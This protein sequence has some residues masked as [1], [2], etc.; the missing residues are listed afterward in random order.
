MSDNPNRDPAGGQQGGTATETPPPKKNNAV[1]EALKKAAGAVRRLAARAAKA[2]RPV[3]KKAANA[4][5]AVFGKQYQAL[6]AT[7]AKHPQQ[8]LAGALALVIL[9]VFCFSVTR[10]TGEREI[11]EQEEAAVEVVA[12]EDF[13]QSGS[14]TLSGVKG[15]SAEDVEKGLTLN[16]RA[17]VE[18]VKD[19]ADDEAVVHIMEPRNIEYTGTFRTGKAGDADYRYHKF[20]LNSP[21]LTVR[22]G[23]GSSRIESYESVELVFSEQVD[24]YSLEQNLSIIPYSDFTL[25]YT[26]NTVTIIPDYGWEA[27]GG[28]QIQ[29][30]ADYA[31]RDGK[32]FIQNQ[33]LNFTVKSAYTPSGDTYVEES[34]SSP[35]IRFESNQSLIMNGEN[36][37]AMIFTADN[38]DLKVPVLVDT[39]RMND[40][41][42]YRNQGSIYLNYDVKLDALEKLDTNAFLVDNGENRFEVPHD[43][44][45][46]YILA[47]TYKD[48]HTGE[49][50]Q[51]RTSYLVTPISVYM[52]ATAMET[53]VWLNSAGSESPLAG[54]TVVFE[55][56]EQPEEPLTTD[57]QGILTVAHT[58]AADYDYY[59][60]KSSFSVYD[61][62]GAL[63]YYDNS[64]LYRSFNY[65]DRYYSTLFTDRT[66]YKPEDTVHFWGFV[67]PY[68]YNRREMPET[69]TV[70]FDEGG[71]DI[72][73]EVEISENGVFHG[74]VALEQ[75]K[76]SQYAIAAALHF[77]GETEEDAGTRHVLRTE[78][79]SVKEF[80][81]PTFVLDSTT[82]KTIYG[83]DDEVTVTV[84]ASFYDGSPLPFYPLEVSYHD[85]TTY[86]K[87]AIKGV[88]TDSSGTATFTFPANP[89]G[90][91]IGA[92]KSAYSGQYIVQIAS[93]G[94]QVTHVN[95][96]RYL[97]SDTLL[98]YSIE[99]QASGDN[100]QMTVRAYAVDNAA[101][102]AWLENGGSAYSLNN[103]T[104]LQIARG[105]PRDLKL[106]VDLRWGYTDTLSIRHHNAFR[107]GSGYIDYKD[108]LGIRLDEA[109][110]SVMKIIRDWE[111][112]VKQITVNTTDG[113]AVIPDLI[114]KPE[115][116]LID[117]DEPLRMRA[118]LGY[119]DGKENSCELRATY[120][121]PQ[122]PGY[123]WDGEFESE[124]QS[125]PEKVIIPGYSFAVTDTGDGEDLT[126]G[127]EWLS[128][129]TMDA[130]KP[131]RFDLLLDSEPVESGGRVLYTVIQNGVY[132]YGVAGSS[133]QLPYR[134][135]YGKSVRLIAAYFDGVQT[136]Y[137]KQLDLYSSDESLKIDLD[138]TPDR[139]SYR[140]GDSVSLQV[141]ATDY[142][143]RGVAGD[144]CVAVVD[145]SI[146][147]LS[148][149]PLDTLY[150]LYYDM[151]SF[152]NSVTQYCTTYREE[153]LRGGMMDG[154][155]DGS[156]GVEFYDSYRSNFKDTALFLPTTTDSGGNAN[157]RFTLPDNT[158]SWRIT[159]VE[160][161]RDLLA[162]DNRSNII[163]SLPFFVKPVLTTKYIEGDDLALLVQGHGTLLEEGDDITYTVTLTGDGVSTTLTGDGKA[164]QALEFNFG[165]R[166]VGEYTIV[167]RAQYS[168]YADTVELPVTVLKSNLELVVH[169]RIDITP[170]LDI[171]A[172]R[173]PVTLTLYDKTNEPFMASINSLFG[174]YCMQAN[175]RLSRFVAK[176]VIRNTMDNSI[177]VPSYIAEGNDY[178]SDMQNTDGGIAFYPGDSS[179][180]MVTTYVLLVAG[181]QFDQNGIARYYREQL[182]RLTN[183]KERAAC[184]L[185]LAATGQ[186]E[187]E[188]LLTELEKES[189]GLDVRAYLIAGLAYLGNTEQAEKLYTE[190]LHAHLAPLSGSARQ[191]ENWDRDA[192]AIWIAASRLGHEDADA[193][194]LYFGGPH[195]RYS[196]L[197]ECMIYVTNYTQKVVPAS[198]TY[199]LKGQTRSIELGTMGMQTMVLSKSDLES[200]R[201]SNYTEGLTAVAYYVGEP[202]ELGLDTSDNMKIDKS[203]RAVDDN[204][205]EVT[206]AMT[207]T[208]D[209]PTGQYDISD[210]VPSN[211]RLYGFDDSY[212]DPVNKNTTSFSVTEEGQKLYIAFNSRIE[213]AQTIRFRYR[214]RQTFQSQAVLDTTYMIHGDS[215]ENCNTEKKAFT[216]TPTGTFVPVITE[217]S[218]RQNSGQG[219]ESIEAEGQ[220]SA[221][222]Q[223]AQ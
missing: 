201:F 84:S 26:V 195:W 176:R 200:L 150:D 35:Y 188:E 168:G 58:K 170:Q 185:G 99:R 153:A 54:Y 105:E 194:S 215:G 207:L 49:E 115:G 140:P 94:E 16:P 40:L 197:F 68:R 189:L 145:E 210:W 154:G 106:S 21:A 62:A 114:Y 219:T 39:Y 2:V 57:A 75:I 89:G 192:A 95:E 100:L 74:E 166:P 204:T 50:R 65:Y 7:A 14:F 151:L 111:N 217:E 87:V 220:T 33:V 191:S 73:Q 90:Q 34:G 1:L 172:A 160:V 81:K 19:E 122:Q 139:D 141:K 131:Y 180:P 124:E 83:P 11:A 125:E 152:D 146:F 85:L 48:P 128:N 17:T 82:D 133:F 69:A 149:Q 213:A 37:M 135:A 101:L 123:I 183:Q 169:K 159:A 109:Q 96:Y 212:T 118:N 173:Y 9:V 143:G 46:A 107:I 178:A 138:V 78:Y 51:A 175:Q 116:S 132:E 61:P 91:D 52:Q 205:Y 112:S 32:Q 70:V 8:F 36:D 42:K 144:L 86:N 64:N 134:V 167:A 129:I 60:Q 203:I 28:H 113:E 117:F 130:G 5:R 12:M 156:G 171:T 223:T 218:Q 164:Y 72:T 102:N 161:G 88:T 103:S 3:T 66:I 211:T 44:E 43:G 221:E 184:Y 29:I 59:S 165:R 56:D 127:E 222:A 199:T 53:M 45:G 77:P 137:V 163:S 193:L 162:G 55:D 47:A 98:D 155:K 97:P 71:L 41:E 187:A 179:D 63:V 148:E 110:P 216:P 147:A 209:A 31:S 13:A 202:G 196:T 119:T 24:I 20:S 92:Q 177:A 80:E 198:Y 206:L 104:L 4:L 15:L 214:V 136:T 10:P 142:L 22:L 186:I 157:I 158:T 67:G 190:H 93:D 18:V 181:D 23:S 121:S 120:Y 108:N 25:D 126:P 27:G 182:E 79:L 174:H 30:S 6:R 76:S 208:K 38:L